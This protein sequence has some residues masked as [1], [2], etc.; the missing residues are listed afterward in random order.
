MQT[1]SELRAGRQPKIG[2]ML[3]VV[4][5]LATGVLTLSGDMEDLLPAHPVLFWVR[6]GFFAVALGSALVG[7]YKLLGYVRGIGVVPA[8]SVDGVDK[9]LQY[10]GEEGKGSRLSGWR[11]L[12]CVVVDGF[13]GIW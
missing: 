13:L 8:P 1:R 10:N 5:L 2:N 11:L 3:L 7:V 9:H 4:G 6:A 12:G